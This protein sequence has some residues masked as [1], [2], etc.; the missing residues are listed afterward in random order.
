MKIKDLI[1]AFKILEEGS[2]PV[3]LRLLFARCNA[4]VKTTYGS[5]ILEKQSDFFNITK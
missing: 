3:L 5:E 1:L 2:A 4:L